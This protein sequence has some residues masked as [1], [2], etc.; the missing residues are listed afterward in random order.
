MEIFR[1]TFNSIVQHAQLRDHPE[2]DL[3]PDNEFEKLIFEIDYCPEVST[4]QP[5]KLDMHKN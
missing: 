4:G 1:E 5:S 3:G 2:V